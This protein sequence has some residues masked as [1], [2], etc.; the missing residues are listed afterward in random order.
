MQK[1][2][3]WAMNLVKLVRLLLGTRSTEPSDSYLG[4]SWRKPGV[5]KGDSLVTILVNNHAKE[6]GFTAFT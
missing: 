5:N 1:A 2:I 3:H 6:S 4:G